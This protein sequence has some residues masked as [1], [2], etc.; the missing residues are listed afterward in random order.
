MK[1]PWNKDFIPDPSKIDTE[2]ESLTKEE[3]M[4]LTK[5]MDYMYEEL[6]PDKVMELTGSFLQDDKSGKRLGQALIEVEEFISHMGA[7]YEL[8]AS[9]LIDVF[10]WA[11]FEMLRQYTILNIGVNHQQFQEEMK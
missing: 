10:K 6:T 3:H 11:L 9:R 7:K 4:A 1:T 8:E 2:K 5:L